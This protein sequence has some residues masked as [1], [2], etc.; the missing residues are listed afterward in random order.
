MIHFDLSLKKEIIENHFKQLEK[1]LKDRINNSSLNKVQKKF[2]IDNLESIITSPPHDLLSLY[3]RFKTIRGKKA[4][5]T[6]SV[7]KKI[8][9]YDSFVSKKEKKYDAYDLAQKLDLRV[10]L[11]CNRMYTLTIKTG[12]EKKKHITRPEFDH[13]FDKATYPMLALSIYNLI[14]SCNICNST[15]K[16]DKRFTLETH[17]HPFIDSCLSN[18]KYSFKPYDVSSILGNSSNLE[19]V[20][21]TDADPI[22]SKLAT[23][24]DVFKLEAI[25]NGHSEELRDL[26]DIRYRFSK[27]YLDQLFSTYNHLGISYEEA[28]RIAFGVHYNESDFGRRPFSKLKKDI[29]KE[30]EII[31]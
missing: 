12:S 10:C 29:L 15:L 4:L 16:G 22:S 9:D 2:L 27:T 11:Y 24:A 26:F 17:I 23:S 1:D 5:K 13:F 28:Y 14:P 7:L 3:E 19:V 31:R 20:I 30:L 18:Y 21:I 6:N 25:F 8:F